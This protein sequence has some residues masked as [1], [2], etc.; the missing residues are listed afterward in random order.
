MEIVGSLADF[1]DGA[2]ADLS[3]DDKT[4]AYITNLFTTFKQ[5]QN[6]FSNQSITLLYIRAKEKQDFVSYQMLGD[7]IFFAGAWYPEHLTDASEDYYA[8]IGSL[9]YWRCH[10]LLNRQWHL[11][12]RLSDEFSELSFETRKL[13]QRL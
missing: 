6:D 7:W 4:R 10:K 1:F 3:C 13:I 9:S 2:F 11:F 12:E 5:T 8:A